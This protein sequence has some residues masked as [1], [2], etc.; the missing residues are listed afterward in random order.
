MVKVEDLID[1][2]FNEKNGG[3]GD[4][5]ELSGDEMLEE[6]LEG[7]EIELIEALQIILNE[8]FKE[9]SINFLPLS[10]LERGKISQK[11]TKIKTFILKSR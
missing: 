5:E 3:A 1:M 10:D 11:V 4:G 7:N 2:I 9:T 8:A 6:E